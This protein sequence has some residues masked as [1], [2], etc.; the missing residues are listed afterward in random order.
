ML[1]S[2]LETARSQAL[3]YEAKLSVTAD[4]QTIK[5]KLGSLERERQQ[6]VE[7]VE[8]E[9]YISRQNEAQLQQII[10]SLRGQLSRPSK[11]ECDAMTELTKLKQK[12]FNEVQDLKSK[13]SLKKEEI[14]KVNF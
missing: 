10:E 14:S 2:Q 6:L 7:N 9:R 1:E 4:Y 12:H 13:V 3:H 5:D 11:T 8:K